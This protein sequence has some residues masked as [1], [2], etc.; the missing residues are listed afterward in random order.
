MGK[1]KKEA[2]PQQAVA[3]QEQNEQGRFIIVPTRDNDG[4]ARWSDP[5]LI[6]VVQSLGYSIQQRQDGRYEVWR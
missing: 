5:K 2:A 4:A 3:P 6:Q 1:F